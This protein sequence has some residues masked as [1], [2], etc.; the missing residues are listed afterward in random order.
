M[1]LQILNANNLNWAN[2]TNFSTTFALFVFIRAI[3]VKNRP[4]AGNPVIVAAKILI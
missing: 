3:R 1:K 4:A 2:I